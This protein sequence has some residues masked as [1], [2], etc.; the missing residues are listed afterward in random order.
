MRER[1]SRVSKVRVR[2]RE[3]EGYGC[4]YERAGLG[5]R[6]ERVGLRG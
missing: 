3:G 6:G 5:G 2:V 4:A 1:E